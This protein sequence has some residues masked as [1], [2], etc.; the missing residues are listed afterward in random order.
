M[1]HSSPPGAVR[2]TF[3][4]DGSRLRKRLRRRYKE[5]FALF[6]SDFV[7]NRHS[8]SPAPAFCT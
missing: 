8:R 2:L 6:P 7:D 3:V 1:L 4:R 5:N